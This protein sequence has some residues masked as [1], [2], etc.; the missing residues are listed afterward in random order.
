MAGEEEDRG[1]RMNASEAR[2][3]LLNP[4]QKN[5]LRISLMLVEKGMLEVD[6]LLSAGEHQGL[7]FTITD[8]LAED[9]KEALRQLI[10]EVREII[11]ELKDR[12]QLEME[13]TAISRTIFGKAPLLWEMVK[14]TDASRL[15][16]YGEIDPRLQEVLDPPLE[17]LSDLL[18][19]M[20]QVVAKNKAAA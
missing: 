8:D 4:A 11:Q 15:R 1:R 7:L 20:H 3:Q 19:E 13:V 9:A 12:F 5:A 16:G 6:R 18:L 2:R 17:R 10:H 14:D